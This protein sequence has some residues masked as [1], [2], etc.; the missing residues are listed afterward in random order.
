MGLQGWVYAK[1]N[2]NI[3]APPL[4]INPPSFPRFLTP[5]FPRFLTPSFPRKR[6]SRRLQPIQPREIKY[7]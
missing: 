7:K 6:E 5:S 1:F 3:V 4:P 2:R